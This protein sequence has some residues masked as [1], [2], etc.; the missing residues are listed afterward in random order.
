MME[1]ELQLNLEMTRDQLA[2][3]AEYTKGLEARIEE[4]ETKVKELEDH[5][6]LKDANIRLLLTT[7]DACQKSS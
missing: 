6:K 2:L 7:L 1:K 3:A 5:L 4:F